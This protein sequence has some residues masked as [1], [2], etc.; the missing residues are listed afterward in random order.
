MGDGDVGVEPVAEDAGGDEQATHE[1]ITA[2]VRP[3]TP[4]LP[5]VPVP[6]PNPYMLRSARITPPLPL[7]YLTLP[8]SR[9]CRG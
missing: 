1:C 3:V 7:P 4:T 8:H 5:C 9:V 2:P 6:L